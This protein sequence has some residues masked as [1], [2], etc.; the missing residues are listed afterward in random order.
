MALSRMLAASG[1]MSDLS[2][3]KNTMYG[4]GVQTTVGV[5]VGSGVGVQ[6][7]VGVGSGVGVGVGAGSGGAPKLKIRPP[8]IECERKRVS[9]ERP[10]TSVSFTLSALKKRYFSET[11]IESDSGARMPAI[12][13]QAKTV[14][15]SS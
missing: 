13:C 7:G 6:V 3:S 9:S 8:M 1:V 5:G 10:A 14:S 2:Q 12:A 4:P 15:E 11:S